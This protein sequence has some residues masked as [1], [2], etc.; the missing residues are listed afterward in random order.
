M[1]R[2]RRIGERG[3]DPFP[4]RPHS[5]LSLSS[6]RTE[7]SVGPIRYLYHHRHGSGLQEPEQS[8]HRILTAPHNHSQGSP[9]SLPASSC[10]LHLI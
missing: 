5:R 7:V 3:A 1:L 9:L 8:H 6:P 10:C 2:C 4:K